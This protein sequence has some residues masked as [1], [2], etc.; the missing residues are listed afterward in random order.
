M[1]GKSWPSYSS[2]SPLFRMTNNNQQQS[3]KNDNKTTS[4]DFI[5]LFSEDIFL[6]YKLLFWLK[7]Q[8]KAITDTEMPCLLMSIDRQAAKTSK[9]VKIAIALGHLQ[10]H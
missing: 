10:L 3:C 6:G 2:E 4:R 1:A 9:R 8:P 5:N 7:D